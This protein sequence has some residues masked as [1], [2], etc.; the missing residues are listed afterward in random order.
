MD[1]FASPG[2]HEIK[3]MMSK[4]FDMENGR[5]WKTVEDFQR[6]Q[7]EDVRLMFMP[8]YNKRPEQLGL[9]KISDLLTNY[10][11]MRRE[12]KSFLTSPNT[13]WFLKDI[14][15]T[16]LALI[17]TGKIRPELDERVE[18]LE[19]K[20]AEQVFDHMLDGLNGT[21]VSLKQFTE[22]EKW[23]DPVFVENPQAKTSMLQALIRRKAMQ[24]L[25]QMHWVV[26]R[27]Y[28][29]KRWGFDYDAYMRAFPEDEDAIGFESGTGNGTAI[30]Q[31]RK[32]F[33]QSQF[34][35][36]EK[37]L[38]PL[39]PLIKRLLN[40]KTLRAKVLEE[41]GMEL[42]EHE[43]EIICHF[44]YAIIM[45]APGQ[46]HLDSFDYDMEAQESIN[47]NPNAVLAVLQSKVGALPGTFSVPQVISKHVGKKATYPYKVLAPQT[48]SF[49]AACR[50]LAEHLPDFLTEKENVLPHVPVQPVGTFLGDFS[51]IK[52]LAKDQI[53][54]FSDSRGLVYFRD[55]PFI[56]EVF[57][58]LQTLNEK[59][60]FC[61]DAMRC[62]DGWRYRISEW[63]KIQDKLRQ[64]DPSY[65]IL[66]IVGPA[67]DGEDYYQG[68]LGVPLSVIVTKSDEKVAYFKNPASLFPKDERTGAE[69]HTMTLD[70]LANDEELLMALAPD[71]RLL[72]EVR[73]TQESFGQ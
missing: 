68:N 49:A 69:Y 19:A 52:N 21:D 25:P 32:E 42:S 23:L 73:A 53:S 6:Q 59:G 40:F 18:R 36:A 31:R 26:D 43:E 72:Q 16:Q 30:S 29:H 9:E 13:H 3:E 5:A 8:G 47:A 33:G 61:T 15:D 50:L 11:T 38:Y 51:K 62:N 45:I 34:G 67:F 39:T 10:Q 58:Y 66:V 65:K 55:D 56:D 41:T 57:Q 48:A 17:R 28:N 60:A 20:G 44:L 37:V 4:K 1:Q 54:N 27:P 7:S 12:Q 24:V 14:F 63:L 35:V 70:E 22:R 64:V 46:T 71:D 2:D